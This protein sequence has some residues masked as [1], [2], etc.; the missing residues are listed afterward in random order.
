[1]CIKWKKKELETEKRDD[2][3]SDKERKENM[4]ES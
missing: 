2:E 3:K 4:K 1:M